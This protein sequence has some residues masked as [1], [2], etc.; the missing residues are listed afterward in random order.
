MGW[1]SEVLGAS[2]EGGSEVLVAS[3][4][5]GGKVLGALSEGGSKVLGALSEGGSKVLVAS[6]EGGSKSPG[7]PASPAPAP[8]S[9]LFAV[10]LETDTLD[11]VE[12]LDPVTEAGTLSEFVKLI[13]VGTMSTRRR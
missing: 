13:P 10:L 1:G 9:R 4:E 7:L 8:S 12:G 5:G 11:E 2:S 6:S 3:S